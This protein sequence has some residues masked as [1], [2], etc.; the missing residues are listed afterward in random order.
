MVNVWYLFCESFTI[1]VFIQF[2]VLQRANLNVNEKLMVDQDFK[3]ND[4]SIFSAGPMIKCSNIFFKNHNQFNN[5]CESGRKLADQLICETFSNCFDKIEPEDTHQFTV[6]T[7]IP[8]IE[9]YT[10]IGGYYYLNINSI[11]CQSDSIESNEISTGLVKSDENC[12]EINDETGY[13]RIRFNQYNVVRTITCFSKFV[14][15][16]EA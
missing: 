4:S 14:S 16:N 3:T 5:N 15:V 7:T 13:F 2:S 10:L 1:I 9:Y 11:F 6:I 12:D 8:N